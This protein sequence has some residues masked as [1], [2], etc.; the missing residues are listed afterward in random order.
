ME[1]NGANKWDKNDNVIY[2]QTNKFK[3]IRVFAAQQF[4]GEIL[5]KNGIAINDA[6]G[7]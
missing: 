6:R 2:D 3:C 5:Q 1:T 4:S 7:E